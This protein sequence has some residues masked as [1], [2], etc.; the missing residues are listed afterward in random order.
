[1]CIIQDYEA[2]WKA[3]RA[4]MGDIYKNSYATFFAERA[5]DSDGG[6]ASTDD[7]LSAAKQG[8]PSLLFNYQGKSDKIFLSTKFAAYYT[9]L[10]A[11]FCLVDHEHFHLQSRGWIVEEEIL[12]CRKICFS[13]TELHWHCNQ[14]SA[15]FPAGPSSQD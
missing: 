10:E 7:N 4:K 3:E 12:S 14:M 15:C 9:S 5:A 11:A 2:D 6:L 1:M 8:I 13:E